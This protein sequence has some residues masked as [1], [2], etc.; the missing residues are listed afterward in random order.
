MSLLATMGNLAYL[1]EVAVNDADRSRHGNHLFGAFGK[2]FVT[3]DG[4]RLMLV[5]ITPRQWRSIGEATGLADELVALAVR[6]GLDF[7]QEGDRFVAREEISALVGGWIAAR[8]FGEITAVFDQHRVCWGQYQSVR[9]FVEQD[10]EYS[11]TNPLFNQISQPNIG[12]YLAPASPLRF[13]G[14]N[15]LPAEPA[16]R[17]GQHT[18][19]ILAELLGLGSGEIGRLHDQGIIATAASIVDAPVGH[20]YI[21]NASH[22]LCTRS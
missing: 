20:L 21:F 17:L 9:Q 13:G 7:K 5:G 2:D 22:L 14:A 11:A 1:S 4:R 18:D 8:D 12:S 6:L 15:N 16:P 3:R 19:E 10:S